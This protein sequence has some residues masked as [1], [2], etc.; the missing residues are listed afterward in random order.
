MP[1]YHISIT[2]GFKSMQADKDFTYS[3]EAEAEH[4]MACVCVFFK[5]GSDWGILAVGL[6]FFSHY[7]MKQN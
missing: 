3:S 2:R 7:F 4:W 1:A 5:E 6:V